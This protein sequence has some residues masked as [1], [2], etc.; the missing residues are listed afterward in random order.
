MS[1]LR[2]LCGFSPWLLLVASQAAEP[3]GTWPTRSRA[4]GE[5]RA[6][7][8]ELA[9]FFQPPERYR[10]DF[11]TFG[12]PLLLADG[13]RVK[14]P[15]DWQRRRA[16]ILSTWHEIMGRWPPLAE[17]PRVETVART[18]RGN[19]TQ[20]HLRLGIAVDGAMV[21]G[22]LLVPDGGG[23]FPAALVVY[24]DAQT[25]VG[26]GTEMRD[27]GW[28]LAKR[29]FVTLSLGKPTSRIDFDNPQKV[30][31]GTYFG[32]AGK[33]ATRDRSRPRSAGESMTSDRRKRRQT[34]F[35]SRASRPLI[36]ER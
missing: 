19:L 31:G 7:P 9:R 26:L 4:G 36:Q 16:E 15:A 18:R 21:D 27:Y 12:S 13:R 1:Y 30:R 33:P 11:G 5:N 14:T 22:L 29:G 10:S 35:A 23:P 28:Q 25:G 3:D 20:H 34:S 32:P 24:Y 2:W 17:R 8:A 6:V